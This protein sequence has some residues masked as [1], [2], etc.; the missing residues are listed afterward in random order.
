LDWSQSP[1]ADLC[2]GTLYEHNP[3]LEKEKTTMKA[4][5]ISGSPRANGNTSA[6]I[7]RCLDHL[8]ATND[9]DTEFV[10]LSGKQIKPCTACNIC[11]KRQDRTCAIKQDDFHPIF[12]KIIDAQIVITGSPVYFGSATPELMA[13]LDRT[14]YV[15]RGNGQLLSRKIG[16]PIAV[17]R[18]AGQN[19]T[20]AQ[21]QYWYTINDMVVPG[22]SYW[23]LG[24]GKKEGDVISD[25]EALKTI[26]RFS[27]NI[28]WLAQ[29][30]P[31]TETD[32]D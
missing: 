12:E 16:G 4:I 20:L 7:Q 30:L 18:R 31:L 29:H 3:E 2:G 5:G 6:L 10:T 1:A 25:E 9:I 28:I 32:S 27:E 22:S 26:D 17:A 19:F 15:S 14:G 11:R 23:N 13:L 8:Q 24:Y 21:L